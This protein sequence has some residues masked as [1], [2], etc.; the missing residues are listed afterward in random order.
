VRS[1]VQT[2]PPSRAQAERAMPSTMPKA[3]RAQSAAPAAIAQRGVGQSALRKRSPAALSS[4]RPA[5]PPMPLSTGQAESGK[6][7]ASA[8]AAKTTSTG[9]AR[10]RQ[11][12]PRGASPAESRTPQIS[13]M[14]AGSSAPRP[15][16]CQRKS[17]A[18]APGRPSRFLAAAGVA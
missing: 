5:I 11:G 9:S 3:A 14:A 13:T 17:A 7:A 2:K 15:S 12:E 6:A 18:K 1:T 10:S 4:R 16:H 8:I